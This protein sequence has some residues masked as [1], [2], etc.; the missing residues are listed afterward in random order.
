MFASI[1]WINLCLLINLLIQMI[2]NFSFIADNLLHSIWF[3]LMSYVK[4]WDVINIYEFNHDILLIIMLL[5]FL[6]NINLL[7]LISSIN[8]LLHSI[9]PF[10]TIMLSFIKIS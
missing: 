2:V 8:E 1:N 10:L 4:S 3:V 6:L 7:K 5:S 9:V